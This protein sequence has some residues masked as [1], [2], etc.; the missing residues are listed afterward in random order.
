MVIMTLESYIKKNYKD[1]HEEYQM[2]CRKDKLPEVGQKVRVRIG[3]YG[4]MNPGGIHTVTNIGY[5]G[6]PSHGG[7][8]WGDDYIE[9]S[10]SYL[11]SIKNWWKEITVISK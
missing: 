3:G 10:R 1:V 4:S 11:C 7:S 2:F 8:A 5:K 9:L 6:Q